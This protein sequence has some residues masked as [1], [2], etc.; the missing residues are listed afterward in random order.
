MAQLERFMFY[1]IDTINEK[2]FK[3]AIDLAKQMLEICEDESAPVIEGLLS[4]AMSL[5]NM[6]IG[7]F[8]EVEELWNS[9]EEAKKFLMP[10]N[11]HYAILLETTLI[12]ENTK[13]EIERII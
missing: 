5:E 2:N 10:Q 1:Y 9:Y 12:L 4:A 11:R 6:K 3:E 8:D 7:E 13:E